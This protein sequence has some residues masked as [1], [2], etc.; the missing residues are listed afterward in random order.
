MKIAELKTVPPDGPPT[1]AD[2]VSCDGALF[3]KIT[4]SDTRRGI[5][6]FKNYH[7]YKDAAPCTRRTDVCTRQRCMQERGGT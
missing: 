1:R 4:P 5:L 6:P 3:V 7:Q 2:V